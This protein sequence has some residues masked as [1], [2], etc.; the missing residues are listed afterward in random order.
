VLK[1]PAL[2]GNQVFLADLGG[3]LG[4]GTRQLSSE[5]RDEAKAL[6]HYTKQ[7]PPSAL[8]GSVEGMMPYTEF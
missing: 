6:P 1:V 3:V 8:E 5:L 4:G 2:L 7:W